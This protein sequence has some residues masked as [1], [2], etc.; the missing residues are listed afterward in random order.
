VDREAL[1]WL[2]DID[3][4]RSRRESGKQG[5]KTTVYMWCWISHCQDVTPTSCPR[6]GWTESQ[7]RCSFIRQELA[8]NTQLSNPINQFVK[9]I[10]VQNPTKF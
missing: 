7:S 10:N 3:G 6:C 5:D 9:S 1:I 4:I 2:S 8:R